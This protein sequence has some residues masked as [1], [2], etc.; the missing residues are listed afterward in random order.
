M[1]RALPSIDF[2][3]ERGSIDRRPH[4]FKYLDLIAGSD[5][6]ESLWASEKDWRED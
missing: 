2:E 4:I 3:D 6:M 5:L 1:P